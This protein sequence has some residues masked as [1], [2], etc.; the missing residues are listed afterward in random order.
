[1]EFK[2]IF[3]LGV[4][5]FELGLTIM[6]FDV[7]WLTTEVDYLVGVDVKKNYLGF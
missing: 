2:G 4:R 7:K 3:E 5:V 6:V 1:M